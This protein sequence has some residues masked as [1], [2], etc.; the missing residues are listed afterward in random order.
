MKSVSLV[1][2]AVIIAAALVTLGSGVR[3]QVQI[4]PPPVPA[5]GPTMLSGSDIGFPVERRKGDVPVGRLVVRVDGRWIEPE[6]SAGVQRL[7]AR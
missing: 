6:F 5:P 1:L 3:A 7:T 2:A 4:Q